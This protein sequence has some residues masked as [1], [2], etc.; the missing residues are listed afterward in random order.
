MAWFRIDDGFYDHPKVINAGNAA[1]GLWVRCGAYSSAKG[2][3][4]LVPMKKVHELGTR[5]EIEQLLAVRLWIETDGGVLIPDFLDYNPSKQDSDRR[6][7]A[8]AERKRRTRSAG[9]A[10][11][12]HDPINGQFVNPHVT[13]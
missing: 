4:G 6:R 13:P 12:S 3:D 5:R 7:R 2:T 9:A 10:A 11:V 1:A 8:D